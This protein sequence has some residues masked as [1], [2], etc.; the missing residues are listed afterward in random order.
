MKVN[1][2]RRLERV[3]LRMSVRKLILKIQ[4]DKARLMALIAMNLRRSYLQKR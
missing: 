4:A 3:D 2:K 1:E